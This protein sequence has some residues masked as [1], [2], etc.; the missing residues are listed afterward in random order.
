MITKNIATMTPKTKPFDDDLDYAFD[1]DEDD[2][3]ETDAD[4]HEP[5]PEE[6]VV[7]LEN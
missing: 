1:F 2:G 4:L 5:L 3:F 7:E 6:E